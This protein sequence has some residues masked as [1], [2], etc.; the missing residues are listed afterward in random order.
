ML[1]TLKRLGTGAR[2]LSCGSCSSLDQRR[3]CLISASLLS[4]GADYMFLFGIVFLT[5]F[6]PPIRR[7]KYGVRTIDSPLVR[8]AQ[9]HWFLEGLLTQV[10][11]VFSIINI[12]LEIL[13]MLFF[14]FF[15]PDAYRVLPP[16]VQDSF[17]AIVA[18]A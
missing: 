9:T 17:L 3:A 7:F 5:S 2:N 15:L 16:N 10:R 13:S 6:P 4:T 14:F 11:Q 18:F 1:I 12:D 8:L